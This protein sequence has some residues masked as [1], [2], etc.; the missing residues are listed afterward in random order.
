M[1]NLND[2]TVSL[3]NIIK[4]T[5]SNVHLSYLSSNTKITK[6]EIKLSYIKKIIIKNYTKL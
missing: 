1:T 4:S 2:I 3:Y 6:T 5:I